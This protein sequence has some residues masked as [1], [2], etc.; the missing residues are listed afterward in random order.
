MAVC[1]CGFCGYSIRYTGYY[2]GATS[3]EHVFC[4]IDDWRE[5]EKETIDVGW[6]EWEN[7]EK[8]FYAWRCKRC[9]TFMFFNDRWKNIGTY[10]PKDEFSSEPM[11]EPFD[12]GPFWNDFQWYDITEA[13]TP[14]AEV[15]TKYPDNLWFAKN[16]DELRFYSDT[17]RTNCVA[18]FKRWK[19]VTPIT[20][21]TMSLA[22]FKKMLANYDDIQFRY[23]SKYYNYN[24]MR[25]ENGVNI[26]RGYSNEQLVYHADTTDADE[27]VNAKIFPDGKSIAE[28]QAE[29]EL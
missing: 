7:E 4:K 15:L 1:G 23:H 16:D 10:T 9:G 12:F 19:V 14:A 22:A 26:Y 11:Q 24:F 5:L 17:A 28:A 20:V 27:I 13:F 21:Q 8:F 29:V 25:E 3:V 6:L 2:K 18:Q